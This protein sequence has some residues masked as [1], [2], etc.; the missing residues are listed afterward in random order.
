MSLC[1]NQS[2]SNLIV[3]VDQTQPCTST[4]AVIDVSTLETLMASPTLQD[5]FSM[6]IATDLAQ[7]WLV[8]FS[9][10]IILYM[11]AWA[12]EEV[13]KFINQ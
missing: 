10:P 7:I 2:G 9:L 1:V 5:I 6:P 11:S 13:V 3:Q 4:H 12:L 8:G